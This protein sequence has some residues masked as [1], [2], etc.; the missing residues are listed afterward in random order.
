S[1]CARENLLLAALAV[2]LGV[3]WVSFYRPDDLRELLGIPAR[4]EPIA[5]LCVGWPDERP[6]RPGLESAGWAARAPLDA[7]VMAERWADDRAPAAPA[8]PRPRLDRAAAIAA[9]DR[10]DRLVK[11][12]GSLGALEALI[13]RWAAISGGP[14]PASLRRGVLVSSGGPGHA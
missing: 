2:V 5:Y 7:V 10:L 1:A 6:V 4:V 8:A 14:P 12:A 13:E 3:V 11:P 9:R